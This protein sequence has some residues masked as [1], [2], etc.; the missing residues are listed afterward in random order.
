MNTEPTILPRYKGTIVCQ[1][2]KAEYTPGR[3]WCYGYHDKSTTT[4][5]FHKLGD[6]PEGVCPICRKEEA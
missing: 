6:I 5:G 3:K 2:C 4:Y 1:N